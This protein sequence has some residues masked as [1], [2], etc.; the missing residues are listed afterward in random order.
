MPVQVPFQNYFGGKSAEGT[1]QTIIN[2]IPPHRVYMTLFAGNDG[3]LKHIRPAEWSIINDINPDVIA[4]WTAT[5]IGVMGGYE[6]RC[7]DALTFL[8]GEINDL[9]WYRQREHIFIYLDPPYLSKSLKGQQPVYKHEFDTPQEHSLLLNR[10]VKLTGYK[11]MISHYPCSQYDTAL[12]GA[13]WNYLDFKSK[14]RKGMADERIYF[15]YE[16]D[17]NL[18]DYNY[19]GKNYREREKISRQKKNFF[20]KLDRLPP[21]LRNAM[22][23]E[24]ELQ[25]RNKQ[26]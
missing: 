26:R 3:I 4:A 5:G 25:H 7:M 24:Y 9:Q 11:I 17:G 8:Q 20:A 2:H 23:Q 21:L 22:L 1:Y 14:T 6:L 10:I 12:I 18:H 13:G 15:N 19:I 16:L